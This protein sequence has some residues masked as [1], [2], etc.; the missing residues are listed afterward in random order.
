[1]LLPHFEGFDVNAERVRYRDF[2]QR[3]NVVVLVLG[4]G[5]GEQER[6]YASRLRARLLAV[7]RGD[8][9]FAALSPAPVGLSAPAL[10]VGD[11]WGEIVHSEDLPPEMSRWPSPDEVLEWVTYVRCRCEEC[12]P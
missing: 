2:W 12:P 7:D 10:V 6:A 3:R 11:R 9:A 4:A 8:L 1:M 5:A